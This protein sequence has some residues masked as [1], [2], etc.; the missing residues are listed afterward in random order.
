MSPATVGGATYGVAKA[1]T[2][3]AGAR[4]QLQ[5]VGLDLGRHRGR[6][7]GDGQSRRRRR[8]PT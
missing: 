8:W 2:L 5:R 1:V 6:E 7:L 3:H 4:P